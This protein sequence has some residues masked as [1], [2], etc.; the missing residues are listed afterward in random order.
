MTSNQALSIKI[1]AAAL[2]FSACGSVLPTDEASIQP[3]SAVQTSALGE[4]CH[5]G[6]YQPAGCNYGD[7]CQPTT[8]RC[9]SVPSSACDNFLIHGTSWDANTSTGPVIY[10]IRTIRSAPD[11]TFCGNTWVTRVT[12]QFKAYAPNADLPTSIEELFGRFYFVP[13]SG[14]EFK[15]SAIQN[16]VTTNDS[17]HITFDV[18]L[19]IPSALTSYTAGFFF[20]GGN[21]VCA[22]AL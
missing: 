12:F 1:L 15:A 11:F 8:G 19:C 16:L 22:T 10:E 20:S 14:N 2:A 18:N 3:E 5:K 7:Y 6:A 9:S 13:P 4:L 17:K 21:E